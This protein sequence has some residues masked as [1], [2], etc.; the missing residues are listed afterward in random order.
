[1]SDLECIFGKY[2]ATVDAMLFCIPVLHCSAD[3]LY[4]QWSSDGL[5]GRISSYSRVNVP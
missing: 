1:M 5:T 2:M 3:D 4:Q